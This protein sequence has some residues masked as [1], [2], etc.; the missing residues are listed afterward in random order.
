M[1]KT[2]PRKQRALKKSE[3]EAQAESSAAPRA[4]LQPR[5]DG[6][7]AVRKAP[8]ARAARRSKRGEG[9]QDRARKQPIRRPLRMTRNL[10]P[11]PGGRS[12][13]L[14]TRSG[15]RPPEPSGRPLRPRRT[16]PS[17]QPAA[18]RAKPRR[19]D[20]QTAPAP[21]AGRRAGRANRAAA[22]QPQ[23]AGAQSA[24]RRRGARAQHRPRDRAGRQGARRLPAPAG[25]RRDQDRRPPTT[26]AR[27]FVPSAG[28]PNITW[29]IRSGRFAGA[30][31]ADQ[32]VH[33]SVG[34]TL[35]RLQG[36]QAPPVA[37]PDAADKRFADAAWRD[38]P[39]FDFHQAGLCADDALG[40]RSGQ[41][42]R[43]SR[44]ARARQGA[45]LPAPGDRAR[46][47]P[48]TSS[49]PIRSCCARRS[50]RAARTSCAA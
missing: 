48:R 42:R 40:G 6:P 34:S 47:R 4:G 23:A 28:S 2:R 3:P 7:P 31:G 30:G 39:Y 11:R 46:C 44:P 19:G 36:E 32:A 49:P 27:W 9:S 37:A 43:R 13:G 12:G 35:Q 26:S 38:N 17:R 45:I 18:N 16:G 21:S 29:P 33:R 14:Q 41:A 5:G 1:A 15:A 50:P 8:Q 24:A 20:G 25:E 10:R 22:G